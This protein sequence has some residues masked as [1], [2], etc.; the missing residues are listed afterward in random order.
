M[1]SIVM[2]VIIDLMDLVG[3]SIVKVCIVME[4]LISVCWCWCLIMVCWLGC[5]V[6]SVRVGSRLVLMLRVSICSIVSASGIELFDN[7][8]IMNGVSLVM[9]LVRW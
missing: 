2:N 1:S 6:L 4:W 5:L 9:L 7:V 3:F 8:Y